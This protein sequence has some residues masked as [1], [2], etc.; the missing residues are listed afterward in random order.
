VE[1]SSNFSF[2][3]FKQAVQQID[4]LL[5]LL[6]YYAYNYFWV[7]PPPLDNIRVMV[8]VW[9]LR[10]NIIRTD[11][12]WIV[13]HSVHSQQHT[14][15]SSSYRSNRLSLSH[16][17]PYAMSRGN[18]VVL[19]FV[20]WWSGSGGIQAWSRRLTGSIVPK[21][22]CNVLNGTLSNHPTNHFWVIIVSVM[23]L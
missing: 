22:T 12:C 4:F 20:T 1:Y 16:W 6:C 17:I 15:M 9:R 8:I 14:Y 11:L 18:Y 5:F 2:T 23:T 7:P 10:G 19:Y 21:V 13:W 3:A